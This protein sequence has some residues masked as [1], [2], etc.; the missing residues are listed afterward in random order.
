MG[1]F[2]ISQNPLGKI[3][4]IACGVLQVDQL[5]QALLEAWTHSR[6]EHTITTTPHR[7]LLF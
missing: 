6:E 7:C 3:R 1:Y 5:L 4:I 2:D